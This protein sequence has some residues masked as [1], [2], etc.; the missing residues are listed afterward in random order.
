MNDSD[1]VLLS[2]KGDDLAQKGV[3]AAGGGGQN[4]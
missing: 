2:N 4:I 3:Q 1:R